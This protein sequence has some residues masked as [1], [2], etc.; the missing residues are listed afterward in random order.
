[1][2]ADTGRPELG[3]VS[4]AVF[5]DGDGQLV[6]AAWG[7]PE[8]NSSPFGKT[9]VFEFRLPKRQADADESGATAFDIDSLATCRCVYVLGREGLTLDIGP[10]RCVFK[11][12]PRDSLPASVVPMYWGTFPTFL[13]EKGPITSGEAKSNR[14]ITIVGAND[15]RATGAMVVTMHNG[16]KAY[17][18]VTPTELDADLYGGIVYYKGS[19][20]GMVADRCDT[21]T[22]ELAS[23]NGFFRAWSLYRLYF[24][25][26]GHSPPCPISNIHS[27]IFGTD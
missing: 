16:Q 18:V 2:E 19:I 24:A 8:T 11:R 20:A 13:L 10:V 3:T 26:L 5:R 4:R 14:P 6:L 22:Y 7:P 12:V 25:P 1:M 15:K 23:L 9:F 21:C 27:A 17:R